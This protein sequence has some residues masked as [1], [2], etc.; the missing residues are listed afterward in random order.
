M[1]II[2]QEST[3][4]NF[5]EIMSKGK[6]F[7]VKLGK[8]RFGSSVSALL[9]NQLVSRFKHA[10]M[11]RG[12]MQPEERRDFYLYVDECHNLPASNFTELLSEA[13]KYRMGLVLATQY[14]TQLF[15][16]KPGEN[17]LS[18]ILGNVGCMTTFRLGQED[19]RL[20]AQSLYPYFST[21]DIIGLPN[22]QGYCRLQIKNA[23]VTPFSFESVM[24]KTPYDLKI[25]KKVR[26]ISRLKYGR[27]S[28]LIKTK[29]ELRRNIWKAADQ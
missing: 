7:L 3:S 20:L 15:S 29:I 28:E 18:A 17:L 14:A 5:D 25:A 24:D 2:G 23:A 4:F 9:A 6:I 19:A 1:N 12:E 8:G 13:R 21:I 26:D 10:A 27:D 22:W 11:K 16:N